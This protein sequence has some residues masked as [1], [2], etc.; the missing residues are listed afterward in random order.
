MA[1]QVSRR[2]NAFSSSDK[3]ER[4]SKR[5]G[6][7]RRPQAGVKDDER[8]RGVVVCRLPGMAYL[9]LSP[10][11]S[12]RLVPCPAASVGLTGGAL[13]VIVWQ[14]LSY[15][16][17]FCSPA[18]SSPQPHWSLEKSFF[19][20]VPSQWSTMC[21][22]DSKTD[23]QGRLVRHALPPKPRRTPSALSHHVRLLI[24]CARAISA[25][26]ARSSTRQEM[27]VSCGLTAFNPP[28]SHERYFGLA[29]DNTQL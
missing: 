21:Q 17:K 12:G 13:C 2:W 7:L 4:T 22:D 28:G 16:R 11:A 3:P 5:C 8:V 15:A 29:G 25:I 20:S 24:C 23:P 27:S 18:T 14:L 9:P 19:A 6:A 10:S 1:R 26:Y